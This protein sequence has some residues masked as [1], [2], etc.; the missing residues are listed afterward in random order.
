[1]DIVDFAYQILDMAQKIHEQE[2]ELKKLRE[3]KK[4]REDELEDSLRNAREY[5]GNMMKM[6]LT[7]GVV[8]ALER[9]AK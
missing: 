8:D 9:N 5:H 3:Y 7:P 6:L 4:R 2:V 1:M